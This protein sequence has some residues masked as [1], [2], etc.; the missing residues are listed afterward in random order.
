M[1]L[2]LL[3]FSFNISLIFSPLFLH[4]PINSHSLSFFTLYVLLYV[5]LFFFYF[6]VLPP[7]F[8]LS[9]SLYSQFP[10][11]SL[12]F[13]SIIS[14]LCSTFSLFILFAVLHHCLLLFLS[15]FFFHH[16]LSFHFHISFMMMIKQQR[17]ESESKYPATRQKFINTPDSL[18]TFMFKVE[19]SV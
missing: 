10:S 14:I 12:I 11:H 16:L 13:S 19:K 1:F 3:F 17:E 7:Y 8:P 15:L 6:P 5:L 4:Y 2:P 9:L 18:V